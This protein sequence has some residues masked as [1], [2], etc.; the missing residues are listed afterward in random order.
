M[1]VDICSNRQ[2]PNAPNTIAGKVELRIDLRDL[3]QANL[4]SMV[5]ALRNELKTI[6]HATG[7]E[8]DLQQ[9]LHI[10]PTNA[11]PIVMRTINQVSQELGLNVLE[12]PSRAGHD[13]QEIGRMT[14]MGAIFVPSLCGVSHSHEEY[15]S[16]EECD[17]G[18][19][20]LLQT[21]LRLDTLD[22]LVPSLGS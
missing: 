15:T 13:A 9:T 10:L 5:A 11:S 1:I 12:L 3:S 19:N 7:T 18:A 17:R 16:P 8:I 14:D 20:V 4:E 2:F 22:L 21:I 6:A